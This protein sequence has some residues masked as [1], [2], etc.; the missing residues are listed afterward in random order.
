MNLLA[1]AQSVLDA[2]SFGEDVC[3]GDVQDWAV[4]F[5]LMDAIE[6]TEPCDPEVCS[7]AEEGD[8]PLTCYR[9]RGALSRGAAEPVDT[10]AEKESR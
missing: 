5:G 9:L 6:V 2:A 1:F 3:G 8:F 10:P 7:C 4:K